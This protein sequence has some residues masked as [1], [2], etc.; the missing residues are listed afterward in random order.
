MI[1][2]DNTNR[3]YF[4]LFVIGSTVYVF[5][6]YYLNKDLRIGFIEKLRRYIY[7]IMALDFL[8]AC[9]LLKYLRTV[10]PEE[11]DSNEL[12]NNQNVEK[13][14][15]DKLTRELE[16]QRRIFFLEQHRQR[17]EQQRLE[18]QKLEHHKSEEK[19]EKKHSTNSDKSSESKNSSES[20]KSSESEKSSKKSSKSNKSSK[21]SSKSDKSDKSSKSDKSDKKN[22]KEEVKKEIKKE[23]KKD[24]KKEVKKDVK[25]ERVDTESELPIYDK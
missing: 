20:D 2:S 21:K 25:K 15:Q 8:I 18:Q 13:L 16:E 19:K 3:R 7:Y 4:K 17:L 23:I 14:N 6:H 1:S 22:K 24:V 5:L 9:I 10:E 11:D 12:D